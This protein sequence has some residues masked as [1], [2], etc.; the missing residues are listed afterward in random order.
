MQLT[1]IYHLLE[2]LTWPQQMT[3]TRNFFEHFG[4]HPIGK[5]P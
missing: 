4:S 2:R 3:L 5:R 1:P